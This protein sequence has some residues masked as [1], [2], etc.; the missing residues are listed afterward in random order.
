MTEQSARKQPYKA[1]QIKAYGTIQ[2][3]VQ[4]AGSLQGGECSDGDIEI[5]VAGELISGDNGIDPQC[6]D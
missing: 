1:P 3:I 4:A 2:S 5:F 6:R